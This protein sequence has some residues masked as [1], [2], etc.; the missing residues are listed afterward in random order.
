MLSSVDSMESDP[1]ALVDFGSRGSRATK[2]KDRI[3]KVYAI[4]ITPQ[5]FF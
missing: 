1:F 4:S 2:G 5:T 3:L